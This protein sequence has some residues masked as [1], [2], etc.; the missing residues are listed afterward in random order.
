M[1]VPDQHTLYLLA[2]QFRRAIEAVPRE[3]FIGSVFRDFPA[4]CCGDTSNVLA[5][6][7]FEKTGV[8]ADYCAGRDGGT[9]QEIYSH[10][11]LQI[12]NLIIDITADQFQDR[13]YPLDPVYVG[14]ATD[15]HKTFD[16]TVEPDA[17]HTSIKDV[18][19]LEVAWQRIMAEMAATEHHWLPRSEW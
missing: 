16:V 17:R 5:T 12:N 3:E 19:W 6:Y 8:I 4:G 14:P 11:W 7:L 15:W 9:D 10:A 18:N 1:A 2:R 13:G